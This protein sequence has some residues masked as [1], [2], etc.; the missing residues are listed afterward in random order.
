MMKS[1][2]RG[3]KDPEREKTF[4]KKKRVAKPWRLE[5]KVVNGQEMNEYSWRKY[6]GPEKVWITDSWE[7]F[8]SVEHA[9][10]ELNKITRTYYGDQKRPIK[11]HWRFA[12][13]ELRLVNK[14]T[15]EI[16]DLIIGEDSIY[17][18]S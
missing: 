1:Y 12:G 14:E 6:T 18:K 11:F 13:K 5:F 3:T 2:A 9:L 15:E 16:V 8:I 7:K 17:A 4:N 10:R